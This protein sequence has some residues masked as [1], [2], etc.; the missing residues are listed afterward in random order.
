MD[1]LSFN[2]KDL[3]MNRQ[4][5]LSER[6]KHR[7]KPIIDGHIALSFLLTT[8]CFLITGVMLIIGFDSFK[9][10]ILTLLSISGFGLFFYWAFR[11]V[12]RLNQL[13]E[14]RGVKFVDGKADFNISY[15][16]DIADRSSE[17]K[18]PLYSMKIGKVKF[19]LDE[20]TYD[21]IGGSEF[22]VYYFQTLRKVILS[23]ENL[24]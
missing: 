2:E 9:P 24:E 17:K 11:S 21:S 13:K 15:I 5:K 8:I 1:T 16:S 4:L 22:R 20:V 6:Q 7:L 19:Y 14:H 10:F 23:V 18:I 12:Q 3:S